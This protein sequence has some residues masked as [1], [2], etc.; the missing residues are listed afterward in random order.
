MADEGVTE[1]LRTAARELRKRHNLQA[2][3]I[4]AVT[5][6]SSVRVGDGNYYSRY[7]AGRLW[8]LAEEAAAAREGRAGGFE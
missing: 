2:I 1:L 6:H 7:G 5:E 4:I 8:V 3:Q